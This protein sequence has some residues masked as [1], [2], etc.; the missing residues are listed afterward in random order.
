MTRAQDKRVWLAGGAAVALV[1]VAIGWMAVLSPQLS[2][3]DTLRGDAG[4]ARAQ[5]VVLAAN[6]AKL[7]RQNDGVG[8]LKATLRAAL[9]AL[10]FDSGLP[11]FTRQ[12]AA[13]ATSSDVALT[14]ISVSGPPPIAAGPP[15]PRLHYHRPTGTTGTTVPPARPR[16]CRPAT[17][18]AT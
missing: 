8:K 13:Q 2:S 9:A 14:T 4:S 3:T 6:V 16:R 12:L 15:P 11:S 17:A 1:I 10:P 7:K 5:N 18:P